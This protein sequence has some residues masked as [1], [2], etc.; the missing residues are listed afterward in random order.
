MSSAGLMQP[1]E[2]FVLDVFFRTRSS[3]DIQDS[4]VLV[5]TIDE[6]DINYLGEWPLPD[7]TL[8][9]LLTELYAHQPRAIGL[10]IYRNLPVGS[11]Y[12]DL[13]TVF[14]EIPVL[15]GVEKVIGEQVPAPAALSSASQVGMSDVI[16]DDDGRVRRGLL[17]VVT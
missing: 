16:V 7:D 13:E 4:R 1:F 2:W 3:K 6:A 9:Q 14:Q 10:D 5:V 11:G 8:A 17:S 12:N 15:V